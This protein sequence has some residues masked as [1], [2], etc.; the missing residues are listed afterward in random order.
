MATMTA[1]Q[2]R[3][4]E[5]ASFDNLLQSCATTQVIDRISNR[6]VSLVVCTLGELDG[7]AVRYNE[8]LRRIPT[9][10]QK[11]LTQ[12]LRSLERD[13]IVDRT[14][15]LSVPVRVD[16]R[17]TALGQSMYGML[18]GMQIWADEH[19]DQIY[20][21]REQHSAQLAERS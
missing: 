19:I 8:L 2:Q 3:E 9:V 16:Y 18:L 12:T 10:T 14:A 13:G 1:A 17:L 7:G 20:D 6:W 11:M 15:T 5:R 4:Q 21:A